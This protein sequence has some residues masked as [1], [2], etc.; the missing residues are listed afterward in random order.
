MENKKISIDIIKDKVAYRSVWGTFQ[1]VLEFHNFLKYV[2]LKYKISVVD[3]A[4]IFEVERQTI[5]NYF[6]LST[7]KLPQKVIKRITNIY[8]VFTFD[9]VL[10]KELDVQSVEDDI[11]FIEMQVQKGKS[12]IDISEIYD[13]IFTFDVMDKPWRKIVFKREYDFYFMWNEAAK[14]SYL[15]NFAIENNPFYLNLKEY[16]A[17]NSKAFNESLFSLLSCVKQ[18][19]KQF[20]RVISKYIENQR[21]YSHSING[22]IV[23]ETEEMINE[24]IDRILS[25]KNSVISLDNEDFNIDKK[26]YFHVKYPVKKLKDFEMSINYD[27]I[28]KASI[29]LLNITTNKDILLSELEIV[30]KEIR[31]GTNSDMEI[32]Y[33]YSIDD[34]ISD[35]TI[36]IFL[37]EGKW[38]SQLIKEGKLDV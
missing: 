26:I 38:L 9:E 24:N 30:L 29:L 11:P 6:L 27:I 3:L 34:S 18:D 31:L 21:R 22:G 10:K 16:L 7:E 32:I 2:N 33:G 28:E 4:K 25:L 1:G 12:I 36:D 13:K 8:E 23:S 35:I 20:L 5:Y 17:K 14:Y 19:D 15:N 37:G